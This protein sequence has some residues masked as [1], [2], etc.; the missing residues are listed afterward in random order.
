MPYACSSP[1]V[2]TT[3]TPVANAPTV[4]RKSWLVNVCRTALS[5]R[6]GTLCT[7]TLADDLVKV[8][9]GAE[10]LRHYVAERRPV[11]HQQPRRLGGVRGGAAGAVE[12]DRHLAEQLA[13]TELVDSLGRSALLARDLD[14]A[15]DHDEELVGGSPLPRD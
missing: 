2:V 6:L 7:Q 8:G 3:V 5:C 1:R 15:V 14:L 13:R 12:Q 9:G 11:H 4:A 10:G